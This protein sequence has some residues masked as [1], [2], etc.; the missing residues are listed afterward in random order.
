M[1]D[2]KVLLTQEGYD[3]LQN[4]LDYLVTEKR[5]E[6]SEKIK[7]ARSF[8][9]LSENAEYDEA[10]DEQAKVESRIA[11]I[12]LQLK[13]AKIIEN[14]SNDSSSTISIG[15]KVRIEDIERKKELELKIVGTVEAD[16]SKHMISNE[17]PLGK[18]L[19]NSKQGDTITVKTKSNT[20]Q[21]KIKEIIR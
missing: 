8:G 3:N 21:Y 13:K 12:E 14:K 20:I 11:E 1:E 5:G 4:E 17:S 2:N 19:I 9:D 7:V 10:K 18:S 15:D 6:V 16:I